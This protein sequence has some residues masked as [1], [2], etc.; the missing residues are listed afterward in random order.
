MERIGHQFVADVVRVEAV[1][2][3]PVEDARTRLAPRIDDGDPMLRR[4]L[5][6]GPVG[7]RHPA[8]TAGERG[9]HG[10]A[11]QPRCQ[12]FDLRAEVDHTDAVPHDVVGAHAGGRQRRHDPGRDQ[13]LDEGD[14]CVER[15]ANASPRH[16]QIDD[17]P[18]RVLG[19]EAGDREADPPSGGV[20]RADAEACRVADRDPEW[21]VGGERSLVLFRPPRGVR[22]DLAGDTPHAGD[23]EADCPESAPGPFHDE[24]GDRLHDESVPDCGPSLAA[25]I[26]FDALAVGVSRPDRPLFTDISLTMST[27]DRLGIVGINGTGKST[28]LRVLAGRQEPESG[29][30]RPGSGVRIAMLD[31][32]A[33]LPA[34]TVRDAVTG[35][36]WSDVVVET[37]EAESVLSKLGMGAFLD[38][39]TASLSGGEGKRVG[40]ARALVEPSDLLVLDEP[41]NHLDVD[42]IMWLEDR[43]AD[44]R[45]GLLLITHDRYVLDR[46]VNRMMELDRGT[47]FVHEG[48]YADYL[49]GKGDREAKADEAEAVRKNLARSELAWLRRGAKARTSKPKYRVEAAKAL[50]AEKRQGA[51][52]P[53]QL[54][55][56][57]ETPRLG[58]IVVEL[59]GVGATAP[60]GRTLFTGVDLTLDRRERLGIV[61]PNGSGKTTL[62]D[63]IAKR[64]EPQVGT[65]RWG[66]TV[67]LAYYDQHGTELD[68]SARVR[69]VVAGPH[70][71]PDWTDARLL[72]A[73][74]FD[75]DAQWAEVRTLS[76]GERRR[77][78][79]MQVLAA[80]PNVLLLDEPTN[81]L[82]LE[83]LRALE[84]FLED[85]P[86]AVVVVSH[87]RAFMRRVVADAFVLDG[88]GTAKRWPGGFDAWDEHRRST[89]AVSSSGGAS[90][91]KRQKKG[92]TRTRSGTRTPNALNNA[93]RRTEKTIAKLEKRKAA[94]LAELEAALGDHEALARLGGDLTVV[95]AEIAQA[96]HEW[97]E[98]SEELEAFDR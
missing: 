57:F 61:G 6:D 60:D 90:T 45:G 18:G 25:V 43:L 40:L 4:G 79:L 37:W 87:D 49:E 34:G 19:P 70:R 41:T 74:W 22:L 30:L 21:P 92:D 69:E 10:G 86:G 24:R 46:L 17:A 11:G 38:R 39:D 20:G 31:Q 29:E 26:L 75:A 13:L 36:G 81:D 95:D 42:G 83:T 3:D 59:D 63:L 15:V 89:R 66:T 1:V 8:R 52:R 32:D 64:A 56:E 85:W 72:E 80:K 28:L 91:E 71:P 78:Q 27:G 16:G 77:L 76:G 67:E 51:A 53:S 12:L 5:L 98:L 44:Y 96:E 94:L 62:M 68:P 58:D 2:C 93:I 82:D 50:V 9:D 73:F 84:D 33:P 54:H 48:S 23:D 97:M 88:A 55:L 35:S 14:V 47:A 65:V 7:Q